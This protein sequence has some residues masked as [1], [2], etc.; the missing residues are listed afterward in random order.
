M[1]QRPLFAQGALSD[2]NVDVT[3]TLP[4]L[5]RF[6]DPIAACLTPDVARRIAELRIDEE[7][8]HRLE[9]LREKANE[10]TLTEPERAE[11]EEFVEGHDFLTILQ[12]KARALLTK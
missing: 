4:T 12:A 8:I 10:A 2:Y 3:M 9:E 1:T 11:Y 5:D 7:A 6:L